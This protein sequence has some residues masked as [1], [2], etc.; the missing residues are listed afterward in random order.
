MRVRSDSEIQNH[1]NIEEQLLGT[2]RSSW[3]LFTSSPEVSYNPELDQLRS[4]PRPQAGGRR[5]PC[6]TQSITHTFVKIFS[7]LNLKHLADSL[8]TVIQN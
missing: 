3:V 5:K 6:Q 4:V 1:S 2:K 8:D 7:L